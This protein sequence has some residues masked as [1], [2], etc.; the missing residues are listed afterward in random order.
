MSRKTCVLTKINDFIIR[1][2]PTFYSNNNMAFFSYQD[3]C[4]P[5]RWRAF[6]I[7]EPFQM[8]PHPRHVTIFCTCCY[9]NSTIKSDPE[10]WSVGFSWQ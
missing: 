8:A 2:S 7:T 3:S 10:Q 1:I 4:K 5:S 9:F 6:T